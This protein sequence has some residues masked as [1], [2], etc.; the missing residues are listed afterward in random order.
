MTE[1]NT[2]TSNYTMTIHDISKCWYL[3]DVLDVNTYKQ[4]TDGSY[5]KRIGSTFWQIIVPGIGKSAALFYLY[6]NKGNRKN[7]YL[8][9]S[10]VQG[11]EITEE[12]D[13]CDAELRITTLNS[14]FILTP[15][16]PK[17]DSDFMEGTNA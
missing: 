8:Q 1:N 14:I 6:D 3:K 17:R 16:E 9:T 11:V 15:A 7:G 5:L 10:I 13:N 12:S 4:R 2:I